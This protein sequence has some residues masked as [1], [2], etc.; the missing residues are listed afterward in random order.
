MN[1]NKF[2]LNKIMSDKK[3]FCE[4]VYTSLS[5]A[6]II[7]ENRQKDKELVAKIEELLK[8][9]I[10]EP[11]K[12]LDKYGVQSRQLATPNHDTHWFLELTKDR[13]LRPVFLEYYEDKLTSNNSAKYSLG[14]LPLHK[15]INK[16]G[17]FIEEKF[18]IVNFSKDDGKKIKDIL[19][20]SGK[21]LID[22]HHNLFEFF[23]SKED[24]YHFYDNSKWFK[25]NGGNATDYYTNFLLLFVCNGIFFENYLLS[26][27]EGEF[28]KNVFLPAFEK[29]INLTGVKPIIVPIPPMDNQND[30]HWFAYDYKIKPYI[31]K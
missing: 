22:F 14:V 21:P 31:N 29:V 19:T 23:G 9:N 4:V 15:K 17:D 26:E 8:G 16:L 20:F 28:T 24:S 2:D 12:K 5:D 7:L 25:E 30:S 3:I 10:P 11:L 27:E 6:I 1:K 13:G 18:S